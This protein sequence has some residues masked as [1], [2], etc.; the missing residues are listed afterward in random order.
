M[1]ANTTVDMVVFACLWWRCRE[2][3]P[4]PSVLVTIIYMR[5]HV[6]EAHLKPATSS[7]CLAEASR[8]V[9]DLLRSHETLPRNQQVDTPPVF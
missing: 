2:S 1:R 9:Q 8:R 6:F 4:G 3:N 7:A 5:S